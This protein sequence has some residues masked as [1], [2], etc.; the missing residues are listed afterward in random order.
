MVTQLNINAIPDG[1]INKNKLS[2]SAIYDDTDIRNKINTVESIAKGKTTGLVFNT[3][4]DMETWLSTVANKDKLNLGDNLYIKATDVPD[5]WVAAVLTS[6]DPSTG[7]Y[8]TISELETQKINLTDYYTK[9]Q[10]Y[11]QTEVDSLLDT[12]CGI[13]LGN[14]GDNIFNTLVIAFQTSKKIAVMIQYMETSSNRSYA[15]LYSGYDYTT[16]EYMFNTVVDNISITAF[17]NYNNV[18]RLVK[19]ELVT[20][21]N[22]LAKLQT[23]GNIETWTFT[24]DNNQTYTKKILVLN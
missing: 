12:K 18:W 17:I 22:L 19:K 2:P 5:Y 11:S 21:D 7:F 24:D 23:L 8:Y 15:L 3:K 20:T 16:N 6:A 13:I 14:Y 9:S 10:T 4:A 1:S